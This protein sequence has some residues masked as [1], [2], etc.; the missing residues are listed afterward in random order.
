MKEKWRATRF[1]WRERE[2]RR[3]DAEVAKET[4]RI[5]KPLLFSLVT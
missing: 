3:L 2:R 4:E 5:E 1:E